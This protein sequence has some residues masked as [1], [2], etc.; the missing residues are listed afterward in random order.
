MFR[1]HLTLF[2]CCELPW[3]VFN[4]ISKTL[5]FD[6]LFQFAFVSFYWRNLLV[7]QEPL[8][9][10]VLYNHHEESYSFISLP[11]QKI[12]FLKMMNFISY[13][14]VTSSSGYFIMVGFKNSF[15]LINPFT[16]IK[17]VITASTFE[18]VPDMFDNHALLDFDKYS[19]EFVL[20][21]SCKNSR[22]LHVYQS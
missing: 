3:D 15:L 2:Y 7:S 18:V 6:D 17:K 14:Y 21:V 10:Q 13:V 8:L 5:D 1:N 20:V 16:R 22:R 11:D 19:E 4:I 12:Y 9:L